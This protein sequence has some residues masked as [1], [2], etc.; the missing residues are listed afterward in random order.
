[1]LKL[2]PHMQRVVPAKQVAFN[3]LNRESTVVGST[4]LPLACVRIDPRKGIIDGT[5][6]LANTPD[7]R[8]VGGQLVVS[9]LKGD[10]NLV[11]ADLTDGSWTKGSNTTI[12]DRG[13]GSF[14]LEMP[15]GVDSFISRTITF[16]NT[17]YTM[18]FDFRQTPGGAA[19]NTFNVHSRNGGLVRVYYSGTP[20]TDWTPI[21]STR[22]NN[23]TANALF[24]LD[25]GGVD[26]EIRNI[27]FVNS[28]APAAGFPNGSLTNAN[29]LKDIL[30]F[31]YTYTATT[32][33][34]VPI[35]PYGWSD[36]GNPADAEAVLLEAGAFQLKISAAGLIETSGGAIST[37]KL[38]ANM[39]SVITV[40]CDGINHTLQ[41]DGET[42]V[43]AASAIVPSGTSYDGN[44]AAGTKPSHAIKHIAIWDRKLAT[45]EITTGE[46]GYQSRLG[47]M[48]PQ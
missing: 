3:Q 21:H 47:G 9:S 46:D 5:D 11:A 39:L 44:S 7:L 35:M 45:A 40:E 38:T 28:S 25:T 1:M 23:S 42:P 26:I 43:I 20:P 17:D 6:V 8:W 10:A 14:R 22:D 31:L 33:F 41:V 2:T 34:Q 18:S 24:F 29:Y 13:D 4:A 12:T 19:S 36:D 27:R 30:T 15:D 37:K 16:D 32:T 48:V